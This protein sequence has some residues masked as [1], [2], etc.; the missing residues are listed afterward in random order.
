VVNP[1]DKLEA[2][3]WAGVDL[4]VMKGRKTEA[5]QSRRN[6]Q[7]VPNL[8]VTAEPPEEPPTQSW[9]DSKFREISQ[10][11]GRSQFQ[12][13]GPAGAAAQGGALAMQPHAEG[14]SP[15][16]VWHSPATMQVGR[17]VGGWKG[18]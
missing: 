12:A 1:P 9:M 10:A 13:G 11:I 15:E 14:A 4:V 8:V 5:G 7:D 2:R 6:S 17:W 3:H 16:E 18:R